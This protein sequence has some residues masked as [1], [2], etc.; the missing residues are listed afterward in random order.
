VTADALR[1]AEVGRTFYR[2]PDWIDVDFVQTVV[3]GATVV[4]A[5]VTFFENRSE[6]REA[7]DE[8]HLEAIAQRVVEL[9]SAV[10]I[11]QNVTSTGA[12]WSV[13]QQNLRSALA[14]APVSLPR[15]EKLPDQ[16]PQEVGAGDLT[17][18]A[19]EEVALELRRLSG[20][21]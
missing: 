6:R 17:R 4:L 20:A 3:L 15:T 14:L 12:E 9:G 19:L 11:R 1:S 16:T 8:R 5:L 10:I 7:L 13:A 2:M 18:L 21:K